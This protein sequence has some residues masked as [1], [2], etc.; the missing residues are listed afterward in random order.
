MRKVQGRTPTIHVR[1]HWNDHRLHVSVQDNGPG[2]SEKNL[3]RVFEPFF[4]TREVGH[5]LGLGLSICYKVVE[6][7]GG[8]LAAESKEGEWAR[9]S[10]DLPPAE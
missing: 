5:G 7:H 10:F 8:V 3:S 4:T 6:S 9:M 1:A 2:I